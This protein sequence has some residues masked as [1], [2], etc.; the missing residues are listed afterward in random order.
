MSVIVANSI[1]AEIV[2]Y[3]KGA[4]SAIVPRL[5]PAEDDSEHK[6]II[7]KTQEQLTAYAQKGLR[8][9][10]MAKRVLS[11][12]EYREWLKLYKECE[13]ARTNREQVCVTC[14]FFL[15][16]IRCVRNQTDSVWMC[17][18]IKH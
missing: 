6:E 3:C 12:A 9:L 8:T 11:Q 10:C 1:S 15:L 16:M 13:L 17:V 5:Q 14:P 4:D 2:L 18:S 7:V